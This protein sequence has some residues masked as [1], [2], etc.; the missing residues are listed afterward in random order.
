MGTPQNQAPPPQ[1]QGDGSAP[2]R[3]NTLAI[4][5]F[6]SSFI[7]GV[8]GVI[9]GFIALNQIKTTGERGR[10]LAIAALVVGC[11]YTVIFAYL[12]VAVFSSEGLG[13]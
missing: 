5:A 8:T 6:A 9:L 7:I 4:A 13:S 2:V 10:G 3:T 12:T 1:H 11:A